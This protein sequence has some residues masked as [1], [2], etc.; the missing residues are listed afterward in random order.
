MSGCSA[1]S[2]RYAEL[3]EMH[4]SSTTS[5]C[6]QNLDTGRSQSHAPIAGAPRNPPSA[7][8]SRS[9][10]TRRQMHV[11]RRQS[12]DASGPARSTSTLQ[13]SVSFNPTAHENL[14]KSHHPGE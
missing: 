2:G 11:G 14:A 5:P 4:G 6:G 9:Q 10:H 13:T 7:R 1:A 3:H 8:A 12:D